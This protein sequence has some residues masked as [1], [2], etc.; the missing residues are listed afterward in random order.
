ME[1]VKDT[2]DALYITQMEGLLRALCE[3]LEESEVPFPP[4]LL[5]WWEGY[6]NG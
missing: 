3:G 5:D 1:N 4:D 2:M 6:K